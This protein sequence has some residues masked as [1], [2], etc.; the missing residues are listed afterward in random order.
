MCWIDWT[1]FSGDHVAR[2]VNANR[3]EL[4]VIP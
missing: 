3:V 4:E 1:R 2:P